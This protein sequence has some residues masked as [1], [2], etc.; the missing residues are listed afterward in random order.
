MWEEEGV[1]RQ[2]KTGAGGVGRDKTERWKGAQEARLPKTAL[3]YSG[4]HPYGWVLDQSTR[5]HRSV[6]DRWVLDHHEPPRVSP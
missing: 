2:A 5:S 4:S 3:A 6:L 1:G